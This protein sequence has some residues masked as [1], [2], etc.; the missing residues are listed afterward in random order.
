LL[1]ANFL[2]ILTERLIL[3]RFLDRDIDRFLAYRQD[4]QV[5]RFQSWSIPSPAQ[6]QSFIKEMQAAAL[7]IPGEWIQIAIAHR[8]SNLL[9]GDIGMQIEREN[10]TIV[11]IGFTLA[12]P[13]QGQGYAK[14][15]V[16]A[17]IKSLFELGKINQII[18]ITDIRNQASVNLLGRL[19]MK[20]VRSEQVEWQGEFCLEQTFVLDKKD[21]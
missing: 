3:R 1:P 2:P 13:E 8:Q 18:A 9:I 4:S 10:P 11:E 17:L 7:G 15:A 12:R 14:E 20:L 21:G 19:G 5:A 16:Q 6:A